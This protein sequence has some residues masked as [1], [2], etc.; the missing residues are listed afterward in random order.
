L[1]PSE[2]LAAPAGGGLVRCARAADLV[3]L[4]IA[5]TAP[6]APCPGCGGDA[7]RVHSRYLRRLADLPCFGIPVRLEVTVRR[8]RCSNSECARRI[9]AERLPGFAGE[10][11]RTTDRLRRS[12]EAIG[13]ALGGE[14][15]SRL[16]VL[17]AMPTS[18]DTLLRRVKQLKGVPGPPPRVVGVDDWAWRKGHHYGTIVVDL[19]KS[20]VIDLLPDRDA[21]TVAAWFK[22]HPGV[23]VISRDRSSTYALAAT[24]GAPGAAQVADRWHLL[25]NLREAVER[26]FERHSAAVAE[27]VKGIPP[28]LDPTASA[29]EV[30]PGVSERPST[31]PPPEPP[32][33]PVRESPRRQA[34]R[35]RRQRRVGRF[36]Q[37]RERHLQGHSARRIARD[38]G[39]SRCTVRRYLRAE[40]CPDWGPG[41]RRTSRLDEHRDWVDARLA[42]GNENAQDLHRRLAERGYRGSYASVR[43]YVT[44]RLGVAGRTRAR[45][46]AAKPPTPPPTS[47]KRLSFEWVR[48][49]EGREPEQQARLDAIRGRCAEVATGLDLADEFAGLIRERSGGDLTGWLAKAESSGCPE[50]R[51]F[52][53]GVRSDEA[54]VK[55]A[56]S[57]RWSNGPVEGHVN[58][59]KA[60]KRQMF[61]RAGFMLLRARV[62]R[63]A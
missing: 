25:K 49:A 55:G 60:I 28:S 5:M 36:E 27:A 42:E 24:E 4:F 46:N 2:L 59:L 34:R 41:R 37:V 8:F 12:H 43:R 61:G 48:R 30:A 16:A 56:V 44:K 7:H 17:I 52:A 40:T 58:R 1:I 14:A 63:A 9:F 13:H 51:Q 20:A 38:L 29:A 32:A 26:L 57:E 53:V 6:T 11:A 35:A 22:A 45:V 31:S 62:L 39:L 54:A 19:E 10:H 3:T 18:P 23:E 33:A 50:L 21:D 47:A 15:G